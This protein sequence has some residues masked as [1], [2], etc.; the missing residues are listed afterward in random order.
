MPTEDPK[1]GDGKDKVHRLVDLLVHEVSLVDRGANRHKW[2]IRKREDDMK[3]KRVRVGDDGSL[4]T[5]AKND[6]LGVNAAGQGDK[7]NDDDTSE[8]TDD[9][10]KV[11]KIEKAAK[12]SVSTTMASI[13]DAIDVIVDA[14][15]SAEENE[16]RGSEIPAVVSGPMGRIA[17]SILGLMDEYPTHKAVS[18]DVHVVKVEED[19]KVVYRVEGAETGVLFGEYTAKKEADERAD[20]V[21]AFKPSVAKRYDTGEK[22]E[23]ARSILWAVM[24]KINEGAFMEESD[25][26]LIDSLLGML[27]G[28]VEKQDQEALAQLVMSPMAKKDIEKSLGSMASDIKSFLAIV[29]KTEET[30]EEQPA[31]MPDELGLELAKMAHSMI[32]LVTKYSTFEDGQEET[33]VTEDDV[34]KLLATVIGKLNADKSE[35]APVI[36]LLSK[37][38][39]MLGGSQESADEGSGEQGQGQER[40]EAKKAGAKLSAARRKKFREAMKILVELFD[41]V[42]PDGE[43]SSSWPKRTSKSARQSITKKEAQLEALEKRHEELE[44][45]IEKSE[46]E[47]RKVRKELAKEMKRAQPSNAA[48]VENVPDEEDFEKASDEEVSWPSDLNSPEEWS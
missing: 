9:V 20:A 38:K 31:A 35:D 26:T 42:V 3:G 37:A 14:V 46:S 28:A 23:K 32:A 17:S 24:D 18:P 12:E 16:E 1:P 48:W 22:A 19:G 21:T 44:S 2:L 11:T 34:E 45:K 41:E 36:E 47:L 15:K 39:G 29:E 33:S 30:E 40:E 27:K 4:T 5:A 10:V 7:A 43:K 8:N 25:K 13:T 6:P